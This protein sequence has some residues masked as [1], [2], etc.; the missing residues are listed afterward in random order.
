MKNL[1]NDPVY[2]LSLATIMG[3]G[4]TSRSHI[5]KPIIAMIRRYTQRNRFILV[6]AFKGR[7]VKSVG[8]FT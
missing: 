2:K 4:G 5:I 8:M 7:D 3:S 1:S 6:I